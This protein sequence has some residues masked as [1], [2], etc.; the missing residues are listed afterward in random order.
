MGTAGPLSPWFEGIDLFMKTILDAE[1]WHRDS[2]LHH[3]P[4]R[5]PPES[6]DLEK[7]GRLKVGVLWDDQIV[8]PLPPVNRAIV[9]VVERLR[10]VPGVEIMEWKPYR[11]DE[12]MEILVGLSFRLIKE[13]YFM[14]KIQ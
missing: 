4:W 1:P 10:L 11:H 14:L 8:R 3:I 7:G 2:S 5:D 9:E 12:A 6:I 13:L